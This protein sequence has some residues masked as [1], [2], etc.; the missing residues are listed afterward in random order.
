MAAE[1]PAFAQTLAQRYADDDE[2]EAAPLPQ[3]AAAAAAAAG[4]ASPPRSEPATVD[5]E[6]WDYSDDDA[7]DDEYEYW[8]SGRAGWVPGQAD[9]KATGAGTLECDFF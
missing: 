6:A 3:T 9:V 1:D 2:L 8:G 7:S 5:A 4:R